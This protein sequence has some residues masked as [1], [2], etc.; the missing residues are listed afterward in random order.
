MKIYV[1]IDLHSTNSY[2]AAVNDK[3]ERLFH[4]RYSNNKDAI[5][6]A[7][8]QIEKYGKIDSLCVESTYN[9]YWLV[10]LLQDLNYNIFLTNPSE[11]KQYRGLKVTNDKSDAYFLGELLRLNILPKC[12]I[13]PREQRPIRDL[14]RTRMNLVQKRTSFKNSLSSLFARHTGAQMSYQKVI[15]LGRKQ[16]DQ[17]VKDS[18]ITFRIS[19]LC[20]QIYS[21]SASISKIEKRAEAKLRLKPEFQGLLNVP[22]IGK[23]LAMVIMVET[24]DIKRFR[25]SGNYT[26]YCRLVSSQRTSNG[27]SKGSNNNKNG[28]KYLAW[29]YSE[30]AITLKRCSEAANRFWQRKSSKGVKVLAYKSLAAKLNKACYYV[31]RDNV[32]FSEKLLFGYE[33]ETTTTLLKHPT[34]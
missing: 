12:W 22:G 13:C 34:D 28:N 25:K 18:D 32:E 26:S 21:L 1:G 27:K 4:K 29:A 17:L 7:L 6:L 10:D 2:F 16:I 23:I 15:Q 31:I 5:V 14:L 3:G 8:A 9:W 11:I 24:G 20:S 30:A 19:E 33:S